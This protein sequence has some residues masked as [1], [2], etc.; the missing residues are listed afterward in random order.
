[1]GTRILHAEDMTAKPE[2]EATHFTGSFWMQRASPPVD[3]GLR[4]SIVHFTP[5]SRTYW[6]VH[7]GGQA[8]YVLTGRGVI[9]TRDGASDQL[10]PGDIVLAPPGVEHW[11]GAAPDSFMSHLAV[12]L[13]SAD[14]WNDPVSDEDYDKAAGRPEQR[15]SAETD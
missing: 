13:E 4:A 6:H 8:L 5:G 7:Q 1:M 14:P 15:Q 9:G 3:S 12:T 11:H 2:P 10:K